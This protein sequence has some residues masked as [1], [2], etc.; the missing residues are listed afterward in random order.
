MTFIGITLDPETQ[1]ADQKLR[2]FL[3]AR[4][5]LTFGVREMEYGAAVQKL[6]DW[7]ADEEG[8]LLARVTPYVYV[9]AQM[10]GSNLEILATYLSRNTNSR[11][12]H[13]YLVLRRSDYA[14]QDLDGFV[15]Y[16]RTRQTPARFIYHNKFS[17]SSYFLPSLY[18]A[19]QNIFSGAGD[20]NQ[21]KHITI[22]AIRPDNISSSTEL[23]TRVR[24]NEGADFAAV[25][26]GKKSGFDGDPRL[27]FLK[28][29]FS[30]PNDLL[31]VLRST[32]D[33]V[34]DSLQQA[35]NQMSPEDINTGDFLKWDDFNKTPDARRALANLRWMARVQ[36]HPV[37]IQIHRNSAAEFEI[38]D[39]YIEAARQAINLS[40]TEFTVF[41]E[42]FHQRFD[43]LWTMTKVHDESL[44]IRSELIDSA[45]EAQ[46]FRIS[47]RR[48]DMESLVLRIASELATKM[49]RIRYVWP[50]DN[51][52]PRVLRDVTFNVPPAS[53]LKGMKVTWNDMSS[54]NVTMGSPFD[55]TVISADINSFLLQAEG[56]PKRQD[57]NMFDF[58][59]MS[60]TAYRVILVRP[61]EETTLMKALSV[62]LVCLFV[63]AAAFAW[64]AA[65]KQPQQLRMRRRDDVHQ[66]ASD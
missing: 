44:I 32:D 33:T 25:W 6:V 42:D 58:D 8:L 52:H 18:F 1:L 30:L 34:K 39:R 19:Q 24:D 37:P 46:E 31:I 9:V 13:S 21:H 17:T 62:V 49:H 41:D 36:P 66:A 43:V 54:N 51:E 64:R 4:M 5:P 40:G 45:L 3:R 55:V 65:T 38:E 61:L 27:N 12:Y 56:F 48:D 59:P 16:L 29:P 23:V 63:F 50:Y 10:L 53:V 60:N 35:I 14:G 7:D 57:S 26:D 22:H 2:D 20:S 11:I 15:Q 47:F 28:L